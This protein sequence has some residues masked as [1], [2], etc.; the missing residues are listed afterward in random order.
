[1]KPL[2]RAIVD[3]AAL[4]HNLER[5]RAT[6]PAARVMAVIKA[7]GYGHGMV[8]AAKALAQTDGFAVARFEEG[9]ALRAAGRQA[10][11]RMALFIG[12]SRGLRLFLQSAALALGAWLALNN[13]ITPGMIIA[14]SIVTARALAPVE[15]AIGHWRAFVAARQSWT[16]LSAQMARV[17][18]DERRTTLPRPVRTACSSLASAS[19]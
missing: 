18:L 12:T 3:T 11:D 13:E 6:A 2:I 17:G 4:R 14:V 10:S 1:M 16:R 19:R 15:Q 7:N 8:P 9:L 5:V